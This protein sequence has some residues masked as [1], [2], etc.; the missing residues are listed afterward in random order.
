MGIV[1]LKNTSSQNKAEEC[2]STRFYDSMFIDQIGSNVV[3]LGKF[4]NNDEDAKEDVVASLIDRLL[5]TKEHISTVKDN[6]L[7]P[8]TDL[9]KIRSCMEDQGVDDTDE[10]VIKLEKKVDVLLLMKKGFQKLAET[11]NRGEEVD[12]KSDIMLWKI[13]K[14][15]TTSNVS[16]STMHTKHNNNFVFN[17]K[18]HPTVHKPPIGASPTTLKQPHNVRSTNNGSFFGASKDVAQGKAIVAPTSIYELVTTTNDTLIDGGWNVNNIAFCIKIPVPHM[19]VKPCPTT[20]CQPKIDTWRRSQKSRILQNNRPH[21]AKGSPLFPAN[22]LN[23]LVQGDN[24]DIQEACGIPAYCHR[25]DFTLFFSS[26]SIATVS[27]LAGCV[28]GAKRHSPALE[29]TYNLT[30]FFLHCSISSATERM[31]WKY[32]R[33]TLRLCFFFRSRWRKVEEGIGAGEEVCIIGIFNEGKRIE[34]GEDFLVEAI[35]KRVKII[36]RDFEGLVKVETV[37]EGKEPLVEDVK[38]RVVVAGYKQA[39]EGTLYEKEIVS[40]LKDDSTFIQELFARLKLPT[41]SQESKKNLVSR[42]LSS[43]L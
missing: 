11:R 29:F 20:K 24:W 41:T 21:N 28:N 27:K 23:N 18:P 38:C 8:V 1:M 43:V 10:H 4:A 31:C 33:K 9:S 19:E 15:E 16:R 5:S 39:G 22:Y 34:V 13:A 3:C 17:V 2:N 12:K 14:L 42:L 7:T 30:S 37:F 40:L 32:C 6:S 36:A 25:S 35:V 26:A